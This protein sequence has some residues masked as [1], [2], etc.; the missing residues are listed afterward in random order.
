M[1]G[2]PIPGPHSPEEIEESDSSPLHAVPFLVVG[3]GAS[4]GGLEAFT[5][6]LEQLPPNPGMTFILALHLD[7]HHE[8]MMADILNRSSRVPVVEATHA[9]PVQKNRVYVIPPNSTIALSDGRLNVV[10]HSPM[11]S[12]S[13]PVDH[14]FRSLANSQGDKAIGVILSGGGTDGTL[15]LEEISAVGGITFAQDEE[16]ARQRA[17]PRSAIASGCVDFILPPEAIARELLRLNGTTYAAQEEAEDEEVKL[18]QGE[19]LNRVFTLLRTG[20]GIDFAQYK[21]TTV[22]R[23]IRRRMALRYLEKLPEYLEYLTA[24]PA[25][26]KALHQDLLIRVTSFFRDPDVFLALQELVFPNLLRSRDPNAPVRI[27]VAGCASGEEVYSIAIALLEVLG[28]R[29]AHTPIKILATDVNEAA[30]EEARAGKYIENIEMDVSQERLARF[31][32]KAHGYYQIS[33]AVRDLCVFS[34]HNV[35]RDAPFSKLDLITCRNLLIYL[36]LPLQKRVMSIFHYALNPGGY[37]TLGTSESIGTSSAYLFDVVSEKY[38]IF[39]KKHARFQSMPF[40]FELASTQGSMAAA[41]QGQVHPE[42][43]ES[44]TPP[45]LQKEADRLILDQFSPPGVIV[46]DQFNILQFRGQTNRYLEHVSGQASLNLL[47]MAREGMHGELR[48]ALQEVKIH[49]RLVRKAGLLVRDGDELVNVSIQIIPMRGTAPG[50]GHFYLVL[51]EE[52]PTEGPAQGVA[53]SESG[54]GN[55]TE[56]HEQERSMED[57]VAQLQRELDDTRE[58]LQSVFEEHESTTEELKS[59]N[60]E[61]LSSNEEMQSTNEELQSAKEELQSANEELATVNEEL[62]GRNQELAKLNDDLINLFGGVNIPIVM[63]GRDLRVR[64]LT[65][66][67]EKVFNLIPSDIGR[68]IADIR[69][70]LDLPDFE[71]TITT[72]IQTLTVKDLETRDRDGRW[73]SVRIRPYI[74]TENKIDGASIVA[75]DIDPLK[76][77]LEQAQLLAREETA[78]ADAE[79]A[80]RTKDEFLAM[81]AHELRNP[82]ASVMNTLSVLDE[83]KLTD[84]DREKVLQAAQRQSRQMARLLEDL[85]DVTRLSRNKLRLKRE[86]VEVS[87]LVQRAIET[88]RPQIENAEIQVQTSLPPEPA[89]I[90]VDPLR[91]EQILTNLLSNAVKFSPHGGH[92]EV[93]VQAREEELA[94]HVRDNGI[95][96]DPQLMPRLF[97]LFTQGE[98]NQPQRGLGVGLALVKRLVELH[99]GSVEAISEGPGKGSDF[100]I[101]L[102]LRPTAPPPPT[103]AP[104]VPSVPAARRVL[105]VDDNRDAAETLAILL[106][107]KGHHVQIAVDGPSALLAARDERPEFVLL[108]IGL[109]GMDGYEVARRMREMP[110][111]AQT[112]LMA[113]SGYGQEQDRRRGREAGFARHFVK[114]ADPVELMRILNE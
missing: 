100:I 64:R 72:V 78:R 53:T 76:K 50:G 75:V 57:Y 94:L 3:V 92:I 74:S 67:A 111:L 39:S 98:Q 43:G 6:L 89:W 79:A 87:T 73:Y 47:R 107:L 11:R 40:D 80:N 60:E 27:W 62:Q 35:V 71:Q 101:K 25:E 58:Y 21:Q 77:S 34:R 44:A 38:K 10:F 102:P 13:M 18:G 84:G 66:L 59:A 24:H 97:E 65:P 88:V 85:L 17:M 22:L 12:P 63:V 81:L 95:G 23:R 91:L 1:D 4:A 105:I 29:A 86:A 93:E 69:T 48:N 114:P 82:L 26:V 30:L 16:S 110:E 70:N 54:D 61:I 15:G 45:L 56:T 5:R 113:L 96:I 90:E 42:K 109:P 37:L 36:G 33:K 41:F 106:R 28:E 83:E 2:E 8:S 31:F 9:T 51:F 7:P 104:V 99:G 32:V 49:H 103:S 19:E 68:S 108:D 112:K 20:S 14:L 52:I 55:G 46:D